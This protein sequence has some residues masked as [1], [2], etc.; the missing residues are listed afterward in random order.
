MACVASCLKQHNPYGTFEVIVVDDQSN[1]ETHD[2]LKEIKDPRFTLMRL[3]VYK[4]TTIKGSKKKAIAYG[5]NHAKGD[6]I[7]TTDA[8]CIVPENWLAGMLSY[9]SDPNLHLLCGPVRIS[10]PKRFLE[11]LQ[12]LDFSANGYINA[13]GLQSKSHD[14]CNGANLAYRTKSFLENEVYDDNYDISSGDDVFLLQKFRTK[15]PQG[16]QFAKNPE[17][18]VETQPLSSMAAFFQQR[19][20]WAGKIS[21]MQSTRLKFL[22]AWVWLQRLFLPLSLAYSLVHKQYLFTEI[23]LASLLIQWIADYLLQVNANRFYK[24]GSWKA[25]FL[26]VEIVHG[27]YFILVGVLSWLPMETN[28]KGRKA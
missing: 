3:G 11:Y 15:M 27:F 7:L 18:I 22:S 20:R 24:S 17:L 6:V 16:I 23:L 2:L 13:A 21:H 14:L 28:W 1:D 25:W 5:V 12:A 26:P 4:K 9:F 10:S 19:M 8:D